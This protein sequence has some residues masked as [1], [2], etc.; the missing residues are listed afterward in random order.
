MQP[1]QY[2]LRCT[3]AK[4]YSLAHA[5]IAVLPAPARQSRKYLY[6]SQDN[7]T[8]TV[9]NSD[10][11]CNHR[12]HNTATKTNSPSSWPGANKSGSTTWQQSYSHSNA[13][14]NLQVPTS[15]SHQFPKSTLPG[16]NLLH[17]AITSLSH[18]F[19]KS[20]SQSTLRSHTHTRVFVRNS[21]DCFPT[22]FDNN[23]DFPLK[24]WGSKICI[25]LLHRHV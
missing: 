14:C 6:T 12:V 23:N 25:D 20:P 3:A 16:V 15:L 13:I 24:V 17:K 4:D 8:A 2:A 22:S 19:S 11:F 9:Q 1:L 10:A 21:E 18:H 7:M 5:A